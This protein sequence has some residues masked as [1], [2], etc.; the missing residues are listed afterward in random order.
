MLNQGSVDKYASIDLGSDSVACRELDEAV[1]REAASSHIRL[2]DHVGDV[3]PNLTPELLAWFEIHVRSARKAALD[4]VASRF[5][6]MSEGKRAGG[7]F[8]ERQLD[9]IEDERIAKTRAAIRTHENNNAARYEEL[10]QAEREEDTARIRFENLELRHNRAPK[11]PPAWYVPALVLLLPAEGA[12]NFES[13]RALK[14]MTPAIA[15]GTVTVLG[16]LLALSAHVYGTT[17]RRARIMFDASQEDLDRLVGWRMLGFA[18]LGLAIVLGAVWYAR[19][20]YL[21]DTIRV[22]TVLGGEVPSALFTIGGSLL[23]N[24]GVWVVGVLIAILVHDPDPQFPASLQDWKA[25]S[26]RLTSLRELLEK[27]LQQQRAKIDATAQREREQAENHDRALSHAQ[28]YQ[29]VRNLFARVAEQDARVLARLTSYRGK[30]VSALQDKDAR[31]EKQ[32]L[33]GVEATELLSGS[34]YLA[35][36]LRLKYL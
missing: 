15:L 34:E 26:R 32:K 23:G 28:D 8:L 22:G 30:L 35:L 16:I 12:I 25:K 7:V 9:K 11:M 21:A 17:L 10:A 3:P 18:T 6:A 24:L 33:E 29:A 4:E 5:D 31:F 1:A 13:F 14:W 20:A 27:P 2:T 19:S 36:T